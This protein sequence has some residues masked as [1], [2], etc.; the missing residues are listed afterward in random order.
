MSACGQSLAGVEKKAPPISL[1]NCRGGGWNSLFYS[2]ESTPLPHT[3][4]A[5]RH[6]C[7]P[8]LCHHSFEHPVAS[9]YCSV[10][11]LLRGL[12]MYCSSLH[13]FT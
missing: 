3:Y 9:M 5:S 8:P 6:V 2:H 7:E 4:P 12:W 13:E 1:S 10:S 11:L